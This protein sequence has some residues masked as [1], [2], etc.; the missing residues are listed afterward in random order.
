[1]ARSDMDRAFAEM[2]SNHAQ[3]GDGPNSAA[4][5]REAE[6]KAKVL[7]ALAD[8]GG[9]LVQEDA[10]KFRG[11]EF[12]LPEQYAGNT[13]AAISF[14]QQHIAQQDKEHAISREFKYRMY[15]VAHA[16]Q[17]TLR[18]V[19]G[20]TGL[21][22]DTMTMF[23][24]TPPRFETINIGVSQTAQVPQGEISMPAIEG[25]IEVGATRDRELGIIGA[26]SV[27]CPR[28]YRGH[29]EGFFTAV[30]AYLRENSIY[31]GK[32][33]DGAQKPNFLDTSNL[34]PKSVVYSD[35]V[36]EELNVHLWAPIEHTAALR[37][38]R[39]PIKRAVL[40]EG[41]YG[42]GKSLSG[43]LTAQKAQA[44]GWTFIFC[45]P[46]DNLDEAMKTAQ[47]YAPAV[48]FFEDIDVVAD[49]SNPTKISKL[50][51]SF[52]GITGKGVEIIAVMTTNHVDKIHKGMLRPGRMDA[53]IHIGELDANG[54]KKL[55]ASKIPANQL[56]ADIDY[57]A[58]AD[59]VKGYMPAF[60]SE[61][62]S[63]ALRY[64]GVRKGG[65]FSTVLTTADFV[66]AA[67][68]LRAHFNLMDRAHEGRTRPSLDSA[69]RDVV[70]DSLESVRFYDEDGNPTNTYAAD[71]I[72]VEDENRLP[73]K[74]QG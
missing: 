62:V 70:K 46:T 67:N 35:L 49:E 37:K 21:G 51:D 23:G 15:D 42:T 53:V 20:T 71:L 64:A 57:A 36:L 8:L 74:L 48:V 31:R 72:K 54:I 19:F 56:A 40:V 14:L 39:Q 66:G 34:D 6:T 52:D 3:V 5:N 10:L 58:I 60:V 28:K 61:A 12:I 25:V 16:V 59:A 43:Y 32:A 7:K 29:V 65:D 55:V 33:I 30:E 4:A 38:L 47:L 41:P 68:G 26:V 44:N 22:K 24:P 18:Q 1:M 9:N 45:R 50:L 13:G 17:Q 73:K 11:T 63:R 27:T 69:L 2:V